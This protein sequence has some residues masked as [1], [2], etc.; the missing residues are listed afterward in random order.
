MVNRSSAF[1]AGLVLC[2]VGFAPPAARAAAL[3]AVVPTGFADEVAI[4]NLN[5]PTAVAFAGNGDV[6]ITEKSGRIKLFNGLSDT[7]PTL[8]ADMS[9]DVYNYWDRG[10]LGLA[11]DPAYPIR[12]YIYVTYSLNR[13]PNTGN[14]W[15]TTADPL[16]DTCADPPS[17]MADGCVT[18]GRLSKLTLNTGGTLTSEQVLLSGWCQQF[19]SHSVDAVA[20]GPDGNLYVSGGDGAA[21]ST[22]DYGQLGGTKPTTS[23]PVVPR[24]PCADPPGGLNGAMTVP[25]AQGGSLRAQSRRRPGGQPALL[26]GSVIRVNPDTA[27]AVSTNPSFATGRDANE[28]RIIADGLR[29]PYRIAFRPGTAEMWIADVGQRNWEEINRHLDVTG[30]VRNYGWPCYEG[31]DRMASW[32]NL[33]IDSCE[34]LY[35]AGP[36]AFAEPYWAYNHTE[37]IVAGETCP[38]GS[39]AITGLGF[40]G[41]GTYPASYNGGLFFA[42]YSRK[43]IWFMPTG[44]NGMPDPA[45]LST[46]VAA[47]TGAVDLQIGPGG[48]VFWVDLNGGKLHRVRHVGNDGSDAPNACADATADSAQ[49]SWLR[50]TIPTTTDVDWYRFTVP[51]SGYV[52]IVLGNLP[53]NYR[54]DLYS[55]CGTLLSSS[56]Q[57][58]KAFEEIYRKLSAGTYRVRVKGMSG[59][60]NDVIAYGLRFSRLASEVQVLSSTARTRTDGQLIIDGELL[61]NTSATVRQVSVEATY[62]DAA[63]DELASHSSLGY[64]N[65][66]TARTRGPFRISIAA[67]SGF[68]SYTLVV[69]SQT[70]ATSAV[71]NLVVTSQSQGT[72]SAGKWFSGKFT[73]QNAFAVQST[74]SLATIY[75]TWGNAINTSAVSTTPTTVGAGSPATYIHHFGE[76]FAGWNRV[77]IRLQAIRP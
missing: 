72:D 55:A 54:L 50:N 8:V 30:P 47:D 24:N 59:V 53:K 4:A 62:Y 1:V 43:C 76:G 13:D 35:V 19:P 65:L 17:P 57:S 25:T 45:Q 51:S 49:D 41:G 64:V 16:V 37:H 34:S 69:T 10:M 14:P 77:R 63:G 52:R 3:A 6:F 29:N 73:N 38:T 67:P 33:D 71:G 31:W 75:D 2:L 26:N 70:T 58:A 40:Y 15:P 21:W 20:F 61:N 5:E 28:K 11:V 74:Q 60:H 46:F 22:P 42:D 9:A 23:N 39:S 32:D 44:A 68:A 36:A 27:A 12:P 66:L 56:N 18:T 48:D 7:T